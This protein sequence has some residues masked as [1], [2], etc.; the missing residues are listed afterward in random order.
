MRY[1]IFDYETFSAA[2]IKSCGA[3]EYAAHA[4]TEILCA[5]YALGTRDELKKAKVKLWT[6]LAN[7]NASDEGAF[8]ELLRALEDDSVTIVAHNAL[9]EQV[10]TRF[11]LGAKLMY[12]RPKLQNLSISRWICTASLARSMA[13]PGKL[14]EAGAALGL[15][16][17]KDDAG[18]RLMLKLSRPRKPSANNPSIRWD[19]PDEYARLFEYCR[20]DVRSEIDLFLAL[21]ELPPKER[22][23]WELDQKMNLK[24][25]AVDRE[26]VKGAL[27]LTALES[28][29]MDK[30]ISELTFGELQ[31]VRQRE[32]TLKWLHANGAKLPN[33]QAGTVADWI[34]KT[35]GDVKR[36]LE[37]RADA[38]KSSTAK[39]KAFEA[40]SRFDG[41][42]RDNTIFYGAHTGRQSGTGLQPQNLFKTVLPQA[43]VEAAIPLI[44]RGD[45]H[46]I[47]AMY[48]SP[49][50]LYAS[51]LRS[52]IIADKDCTLDVGDFATIEVRVLFWLAGNTKGLDAI[53]EGRDLY[54]EMA[55]V[56]YRR[57]LAELTA[58]YLAG[59]AKAKK[60]RQLGK[61]V[62]LGA[63]FGIGAAKFMASCLQQKIEVSEELAQLAVKTY[64]NSHAAIPAFWKNI[65]RAAIAAV[66]NKGKRYRIGKL[67]WGME[68]KFLTCE[69][70]IGRK[71]HYFEPRI[72]MKQSFYGE[73]PQLTYLG[74]NSVTKKF[75]RAEVW[76][77]VLTENV[78]QAVARDLLMESLLRLDASE[79]YSPVLSVH[80]EIVCERKLGVGS[81]E[82]FEKIMK[83]SPAW[84]EGIPIGVE[85]WSERRY[86][87]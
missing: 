48:P 69:L 33:L 50:K 44:K 27:K 24:G 7:T 25:F 30:E 73:Q 61:T 9:F 78:V 43:D 4:S 31:S 56:I 85:A 16:E 51:A 12:S 45:F 6:P 36:M 54:L 11:V 84:S 87:K 81:V 1:L 15:T 63:G 2:D 62:V 37:I 53:R 29:E 17:Q 65:E 13:L 23:L 57:P 74:V 64:R 18:H 19:D 28:E 72:K 70:P 76:G 80:D 39:Y 42:A 38:S 59:E 46:A 47:K 40:R 82:E 60:Q 52:A 79:H 22:K 26:L 10:I 32:A 14:A 21:P 35:K 66:K 55:S 5:A 49:M 71:L 67:V 68:G 77:G 83:E 41:R 34:P 75:D 86:R 20:Q 8:G 3:F 58:A